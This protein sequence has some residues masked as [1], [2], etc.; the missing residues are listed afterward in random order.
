MFIN[1]QVLPRG[2]PSV[3][4]MFQPAVLDNLP[5]HLKR[6]PDP[7]PG[8]NEPRGL[9]TVIIKKILPKNICPPLHTAV[10]N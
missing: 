8:D 1:F 2:V 10:C 5:P 7:R 6:E 3:F 4:R 9:R